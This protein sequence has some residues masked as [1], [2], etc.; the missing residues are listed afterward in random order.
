VILECLAHDDFAA[1]DWYQKAA[2]QGYAAAEEE[3]GSLFYTGRGRAKNYNEALK[4]FGRAADK[5]SLTAKLFVGLMHYNGEGTP[6][7]YIVAAHWFGQA[8]EQGEYQAQL[9][10]ADIYAE[11][12]GVPQDYVQAYKWIILAAAC[13]PAWS[14]D[15]ESSIKARDQFAAKMT[16]AQIAEAQKLASEWKP[17]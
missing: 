9:Q 15:R 10:L 2:D 5:G 8:A 1:A 16:S 3:L 13:W 7:N 14:A 11:G 6:Q 4:W 17:K 12:H